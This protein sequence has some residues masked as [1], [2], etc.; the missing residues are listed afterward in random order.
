MWHSYSTEIVTALLSGDND[1]FKK[2]N[3]HKNIALKNKPYS[4]YL[5]LFSS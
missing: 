3:H 2:I 1:K 4:S 5:S